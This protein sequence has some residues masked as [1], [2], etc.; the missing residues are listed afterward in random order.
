MIRHCDPLR[1]QTAQ[2]LEELARQLEELIAEQ[3]PEAGE[4]LQNALQVIAALW[5]E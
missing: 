5:T 1:L 3:Q 2:Q 4:K